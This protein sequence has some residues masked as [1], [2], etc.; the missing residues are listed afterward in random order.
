MATDVVIH[1]QAVSSTKLWFGLAGSVV[2][3][4]ILGF[5]DLLIVW[6]ACGY[7][8][9]YG[10]DK[11]RAYARVLSFAITLILFVVAFAAGA[12]SYRNW[13]MLSHQRRFLEA[14]ATDRREFMAVLGVIISVTLGMSI[15]WLSL[16]PLLI[17]LC[18]RAK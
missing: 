13:R 15:V 5:L 7:A 4:L 10:V 18:V 2:A 1:P 8:S 11:A 3:W 17:E 6:Q 16:P 12:T 9:L 14:S